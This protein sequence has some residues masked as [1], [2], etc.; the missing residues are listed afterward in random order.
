MKVKPG[1]SFAFVQEMTEFVSWPL[2]FSKLFLVSRT[3]KIDRFSIMTFAEEVVSHCQPPSI[4]L[5]SKAYMCRDLFLC[6]NFAAAIQSLQPKTFCNFFFNMSN[7][8]LLSNSSALFCNY[9]FLLLFRIKFTRISTSFSILCQNF[10]I[11]KA[12]Q[13]I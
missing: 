13:G 10:S 7:Y 11:L 2:V 12:F 3:A 5:F 1:K 8:W 4:I 9:F 6:G